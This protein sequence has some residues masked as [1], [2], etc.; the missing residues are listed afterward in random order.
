MAQNG[1]K[2]DTG[3][4]AVGGITASLVT[5]LY[6]SFMRPNGWKS[7]HVGAGI[8]LTGFALWHASQQAGHRRRALI[9]EK[10]KAAAKAAAE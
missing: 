1:K 5:L 7:L 4:I 9:N 10:K 2:I 8:A 6:S 3:T